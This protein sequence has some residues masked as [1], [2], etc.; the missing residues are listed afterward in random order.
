[1][2]GA[3]NTTAHATEHTAEHAEHAEGAT[4]VA[5]TIVIGA[6]LAGLAAARAL[7]SRGHR[8]T[9]LEARDRTGGRVHSI[10]APGLD[11][12]I[13]LGAEWIAGE[14]RVH[15]LLREAGTTLHHADGEFVV[16][17]PEEEPEHVDEQEEL[18]GAVLERLREAMADFDGDLPL[19]EALERWCSDP[20]LAHDRMMLLSYAQG[21]HAADPAR[22]STRWFLL[23]EENQS[24]GESEYRSA[25]GSSRVVSLLQEGLGERCTVHLETVVTRVEWRPGAVA[26]HATQGGRDVTFEGSRLVVTLPIGVLS[27]APGSEGS[28]T[29]DPPLGGKQEALSHIAMGP[30]LRVTLVFRE[31]FWRDLPEFEDFLFV[32]SFDQPLPTWWRLDPDTLPALVGWAAGPQLTFAGTLEGDALRDAA[33]RS[34]AHAF[35]VPVGTVRQGLVSWHAHDWTRDPYSRGAYTYMLTGGADAH[36]ALGEPVE[37][38]LYFAGEATAGDGFNATMEGAVRS[39][40]RVASEILGAR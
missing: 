11:S 39:G 12:P 31:A 23:V 9:V 38:T 4:D 19:A 10:R 28:V 27:L 17:L 24:A 1:M 15:E 2:S 37:G 6:G 35:G 26:V 25:E 29:F 21:F 5:R 16:Q 7:A 22:C 33:V 40:E 8:V 34:M 30:A 3:E 14:G 20:G 36:R 13:E 18:A 32:Q